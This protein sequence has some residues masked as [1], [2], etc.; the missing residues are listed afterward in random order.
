M[1]APVIHDD[2]YRYF[3]VESILS[4]LDLSSINK[5]PGTNKIELELSK[6]QFY[7]KPLNFDEFLNKLLYNVI[8]EDTEELWWENN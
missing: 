4:R 3:K 2:T 1:V 8:F 7:T 6:E 5:I